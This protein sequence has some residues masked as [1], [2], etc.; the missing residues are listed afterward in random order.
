MSA[1]VV[2]GG[3]AG[4]AAAWALAEEG[5]SPTLVHGWEG[6]SAMGSGA[7]D[8]SPWSEAPDSS[9]ISR[10]MERFLRRLGAG[11]P[12]HAAWVAT[13]AGVVR[14]ARALDEAVLDLGALGGRRVG[15]VD[16][17]RPQWAARNLARTYQASGWARRTRTS[18]QAVS[19]DRSELPV[20]ELSSAD[21]AD[22]LLAR[23]LE[24]LAA[25][26][27]RAPQ[28]LAA[29][30]LG[31]FVGAEPGFVGRLSRRVGRPVGEALSEPGDAA[32]LRF[33]RGR[34]RLLESSG[35]HVV[36]GRVIRIQRAQAGYRGQV[37]PE[38]PEGAEEAEALGGRVFRHVLLAVG[39]VAAGGIRFLSGEDRAGGRSFSLSVDAPVRLRL[40]R[41][42]VIIHA[43]AYGLDLQALGLDALSSVGVAVAEGHRAGTAPGLYAI[44]DVVADR[45]RTAL[46]AVE[47]G[48]E[49]ARA[50]LT[51]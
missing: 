40:R 49:A 18:F 48:L 36:R 26:L 51:T 31:P 33:E 13:S 35:V 45:P 27:E 39:G 34:D 47:S 37:E 17:G 16:V 9:L 24:A 2:G 42:E 6:A 41:R 19:I 5:L 46:A 20:P 1:L 32:G 12:P 3:L 21:Y 30:L 38:G 25:P 11:A 23:G 4:L 43:G 50:V 8:L 14:P 10:Q 28:T 29:F 7:Y 15:V 44:G 22:E